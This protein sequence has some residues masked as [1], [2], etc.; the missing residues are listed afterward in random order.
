MKTRSSSGVGQK[1]D[2]EFDVE[3]LRI[4]D[5]DEEETQG[6]NYQAA[7]PGA[8]ILDGLKKTSEFQRAQPKE[9]F[10]PLNPAHNAGRDEDPTQGSN[11][12]KVRGT[13]DTARIRTMLANLNSEKD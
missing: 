1:V 10:D 3:S 5:L 8:A 4:K 11:I 6:G 2:L 13:V 7:K 9:G 12:G